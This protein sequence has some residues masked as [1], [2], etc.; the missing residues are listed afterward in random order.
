M[1]IIQY[2]A[3]DA[4]IWVK[5]FHQRLSAV[6]VT[7]TE[8]TWEAEVTDGHLTVHVKET[9]SSPVWV[10][11]RWHTVRFSFNSRHIKPKLHS[12]AQPPLGS[13]FPNQTF[14]PLRKATGVKGMVRVSRYL[15]HLGG[16]CLSDYFRCI[17]NVWGRAI[18]FLMAF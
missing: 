15:P 2:A 12:A 6:E 4:V 14:A 8:V 7:N 16:V 18:R 3:P 5:G 9:L 13:P 11:S 10:H 1:Y 17:S